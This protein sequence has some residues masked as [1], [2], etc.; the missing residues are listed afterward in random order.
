MEEFSVSSEELWWLDL[1]YSR[2]KSLP[3]ELCSLASLQ[4]LWLFR[5]KELIELPN[6]IKALSRLKI[7]DVHHCCR[8]RSL[9]ELP[10]FVISLDASNC[11]SLDTIFNLKATFSLNMI[12]MSFENLNCRMVL[13]LHGEAALIQDGALLNWLHQ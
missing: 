4:E 3:N 1:S 5:C 12:S 13:F 9:P 11:K 10:L 2:L 7:L 8:L 6:N